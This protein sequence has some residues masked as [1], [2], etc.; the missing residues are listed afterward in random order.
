MI[1]RDRAPV[2]GPVAGLATR[3]IGAAMDVLFHM[4]GGTGRRHPFPVF[5]DMTPQ[6]GDRPV[7][8]GQ[9]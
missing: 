4:T 2:G 6:T 1:E 5:P 7:R 9:G 3:S 8:S